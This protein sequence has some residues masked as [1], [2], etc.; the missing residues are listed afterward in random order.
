MYLRSIEQTDGDYSNSQSPKFNDFQNERG[1]A[2]KINQQIQD[3]SMT[4]SQPFHESHF[5]TFY[6]KKMSPNSTFS[7]ERHGTSKDFGRASINSKDIEII[8]K[9]TNDYLI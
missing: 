4:P 6:T 3:T 1:Q 5:G 8:D 2:S 9:S 7:I